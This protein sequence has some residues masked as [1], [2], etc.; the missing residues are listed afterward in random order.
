MSRPDSAVRPARA[1]GEILDLAI[2]E[3]SG[4]VLV[5][6]LMLQLRDELG[7]AAAALYLHG[8]EGLELEI[9]AGSGE[10]APRLEEGASDP[11]R[12]I[13]LPGSLLLLDGSAAAPP[14]DTLAALAAAV[15]A[16]ILERR[17]KR[18]RFEV[19]YRGVELEALYDVGLAIAST[20]NLDELS[21]EILL[22]AVSLLDARR[23]ALYLVHG[24]GYRLHNAVGGEARGRLDADDPQIGRIC[25]AEGA[26]EQDLLPGARHLLAV[27]IEVEREPRGLLVVAEK[28]S[29][30]GVGPFQRGDRRTLGL[31]ANQAA[32][33]L[34]NARLHRQA[35]EKERL[36]REAELAAEIQRRL[37]PRRL[38]ELEGLE[39]EAWSR[40]AREVGGDYYDLLP[41]DGG[42]LAALVAD[43]SGK[44]MP[45]ALM[46]STLHSAFRLLLDS[47]GP[48]P[49]LV[50]RLNQHIYESIASNKFITLL[51]AQV[52]PVGGEVSYVNA[53]HNPGLL[54]RRGGEVEELLPGG[55]PLG[56]FASSTCAAGSMQMAAGDLLCFYSDGITECES[57]EDEEFGADR[58]VDLLRA[59]SGRPLGEIVRAVDRELRR[60]ARGVPQ[61]DDQT[62]LLLRKL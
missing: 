51:L 22:R 23:G 29:R 27:P 57:P 46:V 44:G 45:A 24:R 59:R 55:F 56:I 33:A 47:E 54:L 1:W 38:P 18:Q 62:L 42:G 11:G 14:P 43:V 58:L 49:E 60:F 61:S 39:V 17:L 2:H 34:E 52:D 41:L 6:R 10:F 35:L 13:A 15:R 16:L 19:A 8:P 36:E 48:G 20:L 40:P 3:E 50:A 53:G 7:A 37:L 30:K 28:E 31:F 9:A 5:E 32:I 25:E 4:R 12:S 21:E 26:V